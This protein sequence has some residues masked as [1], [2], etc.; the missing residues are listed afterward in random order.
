MKTALRVAACIAL[1]SFS[2]KAALAH[3]SFLSQFD[4]KKPKIIK[5]K[6]VKMNWRNPHA[7]FLVEV[8]ETGKPVVWEVEMGSP[9]TLVRHG[10]KNSTLQAGDIISVDGYLARSGDPLINA[11]GIKWADGRVINTGS[12]YTAAQ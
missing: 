12:S 9:N 11:K 3:H 8:T 7:T 4:P 10:W 5:G 1:A 6:V 2:G